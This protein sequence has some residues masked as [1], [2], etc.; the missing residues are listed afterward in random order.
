MTIQIELFLIW[1]VVLSEQILLLL[2]QWNTE[3]K[4]ERERKKKKKKEKETNR[5]TYC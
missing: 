2:V 1:E 3:R 4:K 5:V